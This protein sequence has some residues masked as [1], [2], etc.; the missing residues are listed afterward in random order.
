MSDA[1]EPKPRR[2]NVKW[3]VNRYIERPPLAA[4]SEACNHGEES[5]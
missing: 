1:E 5:H 3:D 4:G 2:D